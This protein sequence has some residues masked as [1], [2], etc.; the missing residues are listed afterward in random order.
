MKVDSNMEISKDSTGAEAQ[1]SAFREGTA[2]CSPAAGALAVGFACP[3]RSTSALCLCGA[4]AA[5]LLERPL[6]PRQEVR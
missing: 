3:P 6:A 5:R 1:R 4:A 2:P